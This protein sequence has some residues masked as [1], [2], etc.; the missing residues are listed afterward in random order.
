MVLYSSLKTTVIISWP[1]LICQQDCLSCHYSEKHTIQSCHLVISWSTIGYTSSYTVCS[2]LISDLFFTCLINTIHYTWFFLRTYD[3]TNKEFTSVNYTNIIMFN[4]KLIW[5][6]QFC[7][8]CD[9][10]Q[11]YIPK[12]FFFF[13][14][15]PFCYTVPVLLPVFLN[16]CLVKYDQE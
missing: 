2:Y 14:F 11:Y 1:L 6:A 8:S 15:P 9:L 13:S 12:A 16:Y 3:S 10:I 5:P 4:W 7:A